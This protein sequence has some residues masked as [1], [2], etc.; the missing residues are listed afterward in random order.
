MNHSF[1]FSVVVSQVF[2]Y[3]LYYCFFIFSINQPQ[4]KKRTAPVNRTQNLFFAFCASN[5]VMTRYSKKETI[6]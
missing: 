5:D 3:I 2:R 6:Q 4:F 1:G